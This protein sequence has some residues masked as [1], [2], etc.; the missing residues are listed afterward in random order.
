MILFITTICYHTRL[1]FCLDLTTTMTLPLSEI[2]NILLGKQATSLF[3]KQKF[4]Q[5]Y[6]PSYVLYY[7]RNIYYFQII[8]RCFTVEWRYE[9]HTRRCTRHACETSSVLLGS[10]GIYFVVV[11]LQKDKKVLLQVISI[12]KIND[13]MQLIKQ[14]LCPIL[15]AHVR[16]I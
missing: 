5:Y 6:V 12:L 10:L 14:C 3:F 9:T 13:L 15:F 4:Y 2:Q 16:K 8:R 7:H 11:Q 1:F